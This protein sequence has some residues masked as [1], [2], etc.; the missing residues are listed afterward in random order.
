M[1]AGMQ[2]RIRTLRNAMGPAIIAGIAMAACSGSSGAADAEAEI[3]EAAVAYVKAF[4]T[5]DFAALADQ[6]RASGDR[7]L[8]AILAGATPQGDARDRGDRHRPGG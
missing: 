8:A 7:R 3:R 6:W 5:S 2:R 4:N 1:R